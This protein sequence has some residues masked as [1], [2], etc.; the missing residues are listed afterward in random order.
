MAQVSILGGAGLISGFL[1]FPAAIALCTAVLQRL[2][3]ASPD[4]QWV[5]SSNRLAMVF[6]ASMKLTRLEGSVALTQEPGEKPELGGKQA[7]E[8]LSKLLGTCF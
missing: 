8:R 3:I 2:G 6:Q 7:A 1:S 4:G 5:K